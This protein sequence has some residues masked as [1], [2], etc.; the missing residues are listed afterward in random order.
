MY[1]RIFFFS[2]TSYWYKKKWPTLPPIYLSICLFIYI[3]IY[4]SRYPW[5]DDD[6]CAPYSVGY[7]R[8]G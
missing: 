2:D 1:S 5:K 7:L 4:L 8:P 6:L 3:S